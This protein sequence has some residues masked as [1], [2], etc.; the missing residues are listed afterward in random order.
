MILAPR[1][2][3]CVCSI[4]APSFAAKSQKQEVSVRDQAGRQTF[5]VCVMLA[6]QR[7]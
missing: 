3:G 6:K 4:V 1:R 7:G 5:N 2:S